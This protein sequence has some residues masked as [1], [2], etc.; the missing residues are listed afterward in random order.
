MTSFKSLATALIM[1]LSLN[2]F[3][4]NNTNYQPVT[5][6]EYSDAVLKAVLYVMEDCYINKHKK[7][8]ELGVCMAKY[9]TKTVPNPQQYRINIT[10]DTPG[11]L[12]LIL[13]NKSG[14]TVKCLLTLGSKIVVNSCARS[15][16]VPLNNGQ[17]LSITPPADVE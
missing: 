9:F 1:L 14:Y 7:N 17:E 2:A 8:A 4:A 15:Q 11:D 10:G 3:A 5:N 12:K 6:A 16:G 13:F